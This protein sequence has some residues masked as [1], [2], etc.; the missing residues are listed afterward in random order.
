[1]FLLAVAFAAL[2]VPAWLALRA[3]SPAAALPGWHAHEML[4]GYALAVLAGFLVTRRGVMPWLLL[5]AWLIARLAPLGE[6][7]PALLAGIAF[8]AAL[9]ATAAPMLLRAAKRR[10]N[11]VIP[12]VLGAL[13]A[14]D[15]AWWLGALWLGPQVQ[16]RALFTAVDLFTLLV[17]FVAGRALPAAVGGYLERRGIARRDRIRRGYELPLAALMGGA[18]LMDAFGLAAGAG[19]LS[20]AAALVTLVRL[21]SWQLHRSLASP[22]LWALALGYLW[23]IPGL[24]LKALA[25]TTG[26][27][28]VT[29]AL[30]ALTLGAVGTITLVMTA[31]I[32][33][34]R[35]QCPLRPFADIGTAALLISAAALLRL[36]ATI[37]TPAHEALLWLAGASWSLAFVLLLVRLVRLLRSGG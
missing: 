26:I 21:T 22:E 30:H 11:L 14:A 23:L 37:A 24:L 34:L 3:L 15:L 8:P 5:P 29:D 12:V 6:G 18:C 28:T 33:T 4:F 25:Q 20:A 35:A 17:L 13:F 9:L 7:L 27:L 16:Q 2:A 10:E 1:L 32:A 36:L 19:W 31:R